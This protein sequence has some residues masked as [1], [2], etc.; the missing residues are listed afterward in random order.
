MYSEG[1]VERNP[2]TTLYTPKFCKAGR[3]KRV[4]TPEDLDA[5]TKAL[6]FREQIILRLATFEGM[7]R[8]RSLVCRGVIWTSRKSVF[9]FGVAFTK[10]TSIRRRAIVRPGR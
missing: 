3:V 4:L 8:G 10:P 6:D 1:A 5:M 9:G 2:A 7:R